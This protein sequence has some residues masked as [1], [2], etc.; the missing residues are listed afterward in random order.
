MILFNH[1]SI[2]PRE[3]FFTLASAAC[4]SC[5]AIANADARFAFPT[6][7]LRELIAL[8]SGA[9]APVERVQ[10]FHD[11]IKAACRAFCSSVQILAAMLCPS[12]QVQ[13]QLVSM[14]RFLC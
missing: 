14:V 4:N 12:S 7:T 1:G 3:S 2:A 5:L 10:G 8:P 6:S 9:L 11:L 13:L